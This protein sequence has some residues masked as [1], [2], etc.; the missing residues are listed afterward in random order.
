MTYTITTLYHQPEDPKT[1]LDYYKST[2]I[3][4]AQ[5]LPGLRELTIMEPEAGDDGDA[6]YIV[7]ATVSWDSEADL[8]AALSSPEGQAAVGDL[9]NFA[10]AGVTMLRGARENYL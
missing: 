5:K 10:G 6:P 1:F 9:D 7:V 4:I 8:D 2:H 3:P